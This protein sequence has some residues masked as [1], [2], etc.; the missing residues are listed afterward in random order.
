MHQTRMQELL[1]S[2]SLPY[3]LVDYYGY[4]AL[5]LNLYF[6]SASCQ[7]TLIA[8]LFQMGVN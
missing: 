6:A 8:V 5:S 2:F 3:P 7:S 1:I 4:E